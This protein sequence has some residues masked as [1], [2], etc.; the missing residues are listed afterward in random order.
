M[1]QI[2]LLNSLAMS[3]SGERRALE[4]AELLQSVPIALARRKGIFEDVVAH[5]SIARMQIPL[6][7]TWQL[8]IM[9][10]GRRR[11]GFSVWV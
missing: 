10:E 3:H 1:T 2:V 9:D 4:L 7:K 11:T 8:W 6:Q 5:E